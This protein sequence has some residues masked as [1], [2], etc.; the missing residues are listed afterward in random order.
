MVNVSSAERGRA[1]RSEVV[2]RSRVR[3]LRNGCFSFID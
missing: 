2:R 3:S 1:E